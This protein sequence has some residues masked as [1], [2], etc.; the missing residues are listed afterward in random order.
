MSSR[1]KFL[2]DRTPQ[3]IED[4]IKK[5]TGLDS[6]CFVMAGRRVF[7]IRFACEEDLTLYKLYGEWDESCEVL[8]VG[9]FGSAI[10]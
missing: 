5:K 3:L 6:E 7:M 8:I 2:N 4:D 9:T 1:I 10:F